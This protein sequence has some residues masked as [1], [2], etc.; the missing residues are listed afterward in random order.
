MRQEERENSPVPGLQG[1]AH[2]LCVQR[3]DNMAVRDNAF[4]FLTPVFF[5]KER[6]K[7]FN[8]PGHSHSD[9]LK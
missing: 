7:A 5:G 9:S 4:A 1:S 8:F 3:G 6:K 2:H